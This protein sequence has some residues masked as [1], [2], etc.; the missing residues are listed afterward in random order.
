MS[1]FRLESDGDA[2]MTVPQP[3]FEV[4][5]PPKL[6]AWD[7]ASLVTWRRA[8]EQYEET[9]RAVSVVW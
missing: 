6:E 3:I 4:V 1:R 5:L 9:E 2:V 7:Q 8:R